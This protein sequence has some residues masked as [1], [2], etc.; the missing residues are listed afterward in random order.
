MSKHTKAIECLSIIQNNHNEMKNLYDTKTRL[1]F[2]CVD[3]EA[4]IRIKPQ[5][6][7]CDRMYF[8]YL[9]EYLNAMEYLNKYNDEFNDSRQWRKW[10][11]FRDKTGSYSY[12]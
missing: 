8:K 12:C 2:E 7:E 4:L 1:A 9:E 6:V 11:N 10:M 5:I 3:A